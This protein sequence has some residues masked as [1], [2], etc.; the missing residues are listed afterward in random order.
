MIIREL[1]IEDHEALIE[2]FE[3]T[4]GVTVRE[5]DTKDATE[6]YLIRNSGLNYVVTVDYGFEVVGNMYEGIKK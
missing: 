3:R 5:A 4:P 6:K 1:K 2:L